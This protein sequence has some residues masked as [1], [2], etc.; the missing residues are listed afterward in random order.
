MLDDEITNERAPE[1]RR[2]IS[3]TAGEIKTASATVL[4]KYSPFPTNVKQSLFAN[5]N[6]R[7]HPGSTIAE[8]GW[9]MK[10]ALVMEIDLW[11][12]RLTLRQEPF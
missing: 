3:Q 4:S 2:K 9:N 5:L 10:A 8:N 6:I 7:F 1:S 11:T 12:A